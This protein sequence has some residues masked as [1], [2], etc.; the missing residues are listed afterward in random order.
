MNATQGGPVLVGGDVDQRRARAGKALLALVG[1]FGASQTTP[2]PADAQ[3][4]I[5]NA[6]NTVASYFADCAHVD[7]GGLA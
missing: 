5:T 4:D 7:H 2:V 1:A 6:L 3:A